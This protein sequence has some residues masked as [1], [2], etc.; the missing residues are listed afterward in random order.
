MIKSNLC[1]IDLT[2]AIKII[3][4]NSHVKSNSFQAY[5]FVK[6]YNVP[7]KYRNFKNVVR[8][9][10]ADIMHN[11]RRSMSINDKPVIT[12]DNLLHSYNFDRSKLRN[13]YR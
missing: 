6:K 13:L 3:K 2:Q 1:N 4:N 9:D 7:S 12:I 10:K 11:K 8:I 5:N